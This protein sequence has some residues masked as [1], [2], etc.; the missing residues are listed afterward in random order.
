MII[1]LQTRVWPSVDHLGRETAEMV[2]RARAARWIRESAE[3]EQLM[4]ALDCVDAAFVLGYHAQR[5]DACIAN[6][7]VADVVTKSSVPL[8]GIAGIDPMDP[9]ALEELDR[10][11]EM[12][13]VGVTVCPSDQGFHP[14]H[15]AAMRLWE[16]CESLSL[17]VLVARPGPL[18]S[19]AVLEF[20]RPLNWDEVARSHPNLSIVLSGIGYPWV[21]ESLVLLGKHERVYADIAGLVQRPWQ[22]FNA[23][24]SAHSMGVIDHLLFASGWP[25]ET[26][27]KAIETLYSVNG[28]AHGTQLPAIPRPQ[29]RAI[30]ERDALTEFGIASSARHAPNATNA[31]STPSATT[32][33]VEA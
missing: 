16:K 19:G 13:L 18:G 22:L 23:L 2:R 5:Q 7:W 17:P 20:D 30:V 31:H 14:T 8:Y 6:E 11:L 27:A 32:P 3:P 4:A 24:L 15:S 1:D 10:A 29:L 33:D 26:P 9:D 25:Q 21:D 12:G 28:F